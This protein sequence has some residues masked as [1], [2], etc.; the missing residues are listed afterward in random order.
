MNS[1]FWVMFMEKYNIIR[2]SSL[3][4]ALFG[5]FLFLTSYCNSHLPTKDGL[6]DSTILT[7]NNDVDAADSVV[8]SHNGFSAHLYKDEQDTCTYRIASEAE[9]QWMSAYVYSKETQI[10]GKAL[11]AEFVKSLDLLSK[12]Q[13]DVIMGDSINGSVAILITIVLDHHGNV[14][15]VRYNFFNP[16][17]EVLANDYIRYVDERIRTVKFPN[18]K[19][20]GINF[21]YMTLPIRKDALREYIKKRFDE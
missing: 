3:L 19:T 21:N 14:V 13:L 18:M 17:K 11:M 16:V 9:E 7:T 10:S 5:G 6:Y 8:W 20:Y 4:I 15:K 2:L 1:K 12:H